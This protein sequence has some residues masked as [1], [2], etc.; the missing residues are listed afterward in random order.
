ME[1]NQAHEFDSIRCDA[2]DERS[3]RVTDWPTDR[4]L[5]RA[6]D[7]PRNIQRLLDGPF[8]HQ[9]AAQNNALVGLGIVAAGSSLW[10]TPTGLPHL[11]LSALA[12]MCVKIA[13]QL[14]QLACEL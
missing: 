4:I 11:S 5:T 1:A 8:V 9:S 3:R 10:T 12:T 7:P 6:S 14:Q 2:V 13:R